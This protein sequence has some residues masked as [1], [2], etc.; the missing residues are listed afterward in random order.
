MRKTQRSA[1]VPAAAALIAAIGLAGGFAAASKGP[2]GSATSTATLAG[3]KEPGEPLHVTGRIFAPNGVTPAAGVLLYVYQTDA[4][5]RYNRWPGKAPRLKGWI[6]TGADGR[7]EY[8]TIRPGAYPGGRIAAHVH[9]QMWGKGVPPQ[10]GTDLLFEGDPHLTEDER[11]RS[12]AAGRFAFIRPVE[13]GPQG[14]WRAVHDL[15][16]KSSGDRFEDNTMHGL[17]PCGVEP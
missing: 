13:R 16:L 6:R 5:G 9:T 8:R 2:C 17:E 7:Y 10:Y 12:A 14:V 1:S 4:T 15:R 3:P 11:R